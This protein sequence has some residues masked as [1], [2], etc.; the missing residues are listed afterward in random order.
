[1]R[2]VEMWDLKL[3]ILDSSVGRARVGRWRRWRRRRVDATTLQATAC[4]AEKRP[5]A[6]CQRLTRVR[7]ALTQT[8]NCVEAKKANIHKNLLRNQSG[9]LRNLG[10]SK[11]Q[12]SEPPGN[13]RPRDK[14]VQTLNTCGDL[15]FESG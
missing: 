8:V 13:G 9:Q 5:R 7:S 14:F 11:R 1:M 12:Q 6:R 3:I 15:V 2:L 4:E 10:L